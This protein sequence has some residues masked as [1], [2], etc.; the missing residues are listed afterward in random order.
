MR[1]VNLRVLSCPSVRPVFEVVERIPALKVSA[2]GFST[3][4]TFQAN[5]MGHF[6]QKICPARRVSKSS[7]HQEHA[8]DVDKFFR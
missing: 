2:T 5:N 6:W 7:G 3:D 4:D 1:S 8:R